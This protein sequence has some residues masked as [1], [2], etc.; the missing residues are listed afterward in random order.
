MRLEA[1]DPSAK[2]ATPGPILARLRPTPVVLRSDGNIGAALR[3]AR[4][5]LGLAVDDIASATRVRA[6][7]LSAIE[8]FE[9]DKLPAWLFAVGYVR[10]YARAL[11][12]EAESVVD[13]FKIEAPSPDRVLRAPGGVR[14]DPRRLGA[15]GVTALV[16]GA[17]VL[18]WNVARHQQSGPARLSATP[19]SPAA[20]PHPPNGPAQLGAPLPPPPEATNPP[21]YQTPGLAGGGTRPEPQSVQVGAPFVAAGSVYGAASPG[22][23][24]ILQA[25]KSTTLIVRS[26]SGAVYFARQLAP[27]EAWRA[28]SLAGLS[29]DV[30]NPVSVMV[31]VG[32][33]SQGLLPQAQMPLS[34]IAGPSITPPN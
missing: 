31:Y 26:T 9:L 21:P 10:A 12:L 27:G 2:V 23:G 4:E 18:T 15:L 20:A 29:V 5:G 34:Q 22:A 14:R 28:P 30:G 13:R 11:G 8:A 6:A 25:L 32:G 19:A 3:E 16:I 1:S 7:H 33:L 17:V 24:V